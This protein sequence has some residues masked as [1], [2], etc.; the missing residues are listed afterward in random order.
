MSNMPNP[1]V[2]PFHENANLDRVKA[3]QR[4]NKD[5]LKKLVF[6]ERN[7]K[8]DTI[9]NTTKKYL[10]HLNLSNGKLLR[11]YKLE[12]GKFKSEGISLNKLPHNIRNYIFDSYE[13]LEIKNLNIAL[14]SYIGKNYFGMEMKE[15]KK[16]LTGEFFVSHFYIDNILKK[17][18][19]INDKD[20]INESNL[21]EE[22]SQLKRKLYLQEIEEFKGIEKKDKVNSSS[23]NFLNTIDWVKYHKFYPTLIQIIGRDN[24]LGFTQ[25]G[26]ALLK[27]E[28]NLLK[29]KEVTSFDGWKINKDEIDY[30]NLMEDDDVIN[31]ETE[32][33]YEYV[34]ERFEEEYFILK[35]PLYFCSETINKDG[36]KEIYS[37]KKYEFRDIVATWNYSKVLDNGKIKECDFFDA[38]LRDKSRRIYDKFAFIPDKTYNTDGVYNLFQG[39]KFDNYSE[40]N[41][42]ERPE[43]IENFLEIINRTV[44][45]E[46]ISLDYMVKY[47]A[48]I[49]QKPEELPGVIL[50]FKSIQ[51]VGK[52]LM[53]EI[54]GKLMGEQY[55]YSTSDLDQAFGKF[56]RHMERLFLLVCN[57]T[58]SKKG[59]VHKSNLKNFSTA[60]EM[61]IELKGKDSYK[62]RNYARVI[63][64]TNTM[65]PVDIEHS[66]RRYCVFQGV[67]EQ[68]SR[69]LC[70]PLF[71]LI[72]TENKNARDG[73]YTLY[74][75]F[76]EID[77]S[78]FEI[79][80]RPL[81]K[82]YENM[83][84]RN[85]NP[86]YD[87]MH[88][89]IVD[90]DM[91]K[92]LKSSDYHEHR[93]TK[94]IMITTTN[95]INGYNKFCDTEGIK[96]ENLHSK[97]IKSLLSEIG[98]EQ[99]KRKI[100]GEN[101][102]VYE[103]NLKD[104]EKRLIKIV[105]VK[106]KAEI[107]EIDENEWV[108]HKAE[109]FCFENIFP[110]SE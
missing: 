99:L 76:N 16:Y 45:M 50:V 35:K 62:I 63:I 102:R 59:F 97:R 77:I 22:I 4:L 3:L 88:T 67:N 95:L 1:F 84:N 108:E 44:G 46:K 79:S 73:L 103:F 64:C 70:G 9:I 47:I 12:D 100:K 13:F 34:K 27:S 93:V 69:E 6:R 53:F 110:N 7:T 109:D 86:F 81:T 33:S 28:Q 90:G 36:K 89:I 24:V 82:A 96:N 21:S 104:L 42:T 49:F 74:K 65:N 52:D 25:H 60:H 51:G 48:H 87:F 94:N 71:E 41:Y 15:C 78:D 8:E 101:I 72:E 11:K 98:V 40:T 26:I 32:N 23:N 55:K 29:L 56:N 61:N 80:D 43:I 30:S 19:I 91:E 106:E 20:K 107:E 38:W 31:I 85:V 105:G 68:S 66:D 37:Y 17:D 14:A 10:H 57:E 54:L 5:N 75:F 39:F 83:K 2:N 58:E 18:K 92:Y